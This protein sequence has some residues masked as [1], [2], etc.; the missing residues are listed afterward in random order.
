MFKQIF[1]FLGLWLLPFML[2]AEGNNISIFGKVV[3]AGS[4]QVQV[5]LYSFVPGEENHAST[6][7]LDDN[8]SFQFVAYIREPVLGRIFYGHE[9]APIFVQPGTQLQIS[10]DG[11]NFSKSL[12]FKG[13]GADDNNFLAQSLPEHELSPEALKGLIKKMS[14]PDFLTWASQRRQTQLA[15]LQAQHHALNETFIAYQQANLSYL[16]ANELFAYGFEKQGA[17]SKRKKLP[18]NYFG[19]IDSVKLHNYEVIGLQSYRQFLSNY[20]SHYYQQTYQATPATDQEYYNHMY[21]LAA[22]HLRSL[23]KYH[24]QAVYLVEAITRQG[25][26][27]VKDEYIEFANECPVQPYKNELHELIKMQNVFETNTAPRVVFKEKNG[28]TL[29]LE[30][31]KGKIVLLR[32]DNTQTDGPDASAQ[33]RDELLKESLASFGD[34]KFIQLSMADNRDAYERMVYADANEYLKSIINRPKPGQVVSLPAWSYVVLSREGLVV[35]NSL[36][37]P[38]NEL[39]IEKIKVILQQEVQAFTPG[40]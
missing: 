36:D 31:L 39:A 24:M 29:A 18:E 25:L 28:S 27:P 10:F 20:L 30:Q 26:E 40:P 33:Q 35:S 19:F 13:Q 12:K 38:N 23:P 2:F 22:E 16:W 5:V 1:A 4:Q 9:S 7:Q 6:T 34:V 37:D 17:K 32:F 14:A 15:K 11:S 21:E 8:N 3:N